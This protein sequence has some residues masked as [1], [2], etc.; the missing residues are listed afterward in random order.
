MIAFVS[1]V[2]AQNNPFDY[3]KDGFNTTSVITEVDGLT[4]EELYNKTLKWIKTNYT[5]P[6]EVINTTIENEKVRFTGVKQNFTSSSS[7]LFTVRYIIE[8]SF[9]DGR[10]K[11]D[12]IDNQTRNNQVIDYF[13]YDLKD[14]S[15]IY[16][17]NGKPRKIAVVLFDGFK[18]LYNDIYNDL[19]SHLTSNK[20]W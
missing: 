11:F 9:K 19:Y 10:Y 4:S 1:Y 14:G 13:P 12:I 3:S 16:K 2:N 15:R 7:V 8:V 5:N 6:D 18:D 20:D 17:D